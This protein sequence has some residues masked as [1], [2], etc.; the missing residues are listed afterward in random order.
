MNLSRK[1]PEP[2]ERRC[3]C[4]GRLIVKP[5]AAWHKHFLTAGRLDKAGAGRS[6]HKPCPSTPG[7]AKTGNM[8]HKPS[9]DRIDLKILEVLQR[10]GRLPFQRLSEQVNLTPRP[11]LERVRRLEKAGIIKGYSAI[12][13]LPRSTPPLVILAQVTLADHLVSQ[14][15]FIAEIQRTP[16]VQDGWMVSGTVDF[17]LRIGCQHI[18]EYRQLAD[19]WL[20]STAFRIEKILTTT[21]LQ[22]IKRDGMAQP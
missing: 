8:D 9:L 15:A 3:P 22:Q 7:I 12:V 5:D 14:Q 18:D 1:R 19:A 20:A 17:L 16:Q 4:R 11:C 13:E 2:S 10:D 21:E 6:N